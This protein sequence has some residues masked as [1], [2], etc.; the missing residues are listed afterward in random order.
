MIR[1]CYD[2]VACDGFKAQ[3]VDSI[4]MG[5]GLQ[6][7]FVG[8]GDGQL[9]LYDCRPNTQNGSYTL[10]LKDNIRKASKDRKPV[11][12]LILVE[13][14]RVL[15]GIMDNMVMA[16][17]SH[18]FQ[19]LSQL[20]DTKGCHLF[21][22]HERSSLLV[23]ANKKKLSIYMWQ[24]S[25]L[26]PRRE[27][28]CNEV[29]KLLQCVPGAIIVGCKRHYEIIDLANMTMSR[30]L[31]F[32]KEHRMVSLEVHTIAG[33]SS[34]TLLSV[35]AGLQGAMLDMSAFAKG[36]P[37]HYSGDSFSAGAAGTHAKS[38]L[39][40]QSKTQSF[41]DRIEWSTPPLSLHLLVPYIVTLQ[42]G[43]VEIHDPVSLNSL[44][45]ISFPRCESPCLCTAL[46]S[47][48]D[49]QAFFN[50]G[51]NQLFA[52]KM[53]P[54]SAQISD[55]MEAG[56]YEVAINLCAMTQASGQLRDVDVCQIHE[57][58]AMTLF[59]KG[60][61][62]GAMSNYISAKTTPLVL[63]RRFPDLVPVAL[64][65]SAGI[66]SSGANKLTG[67]VLQ[68]AAA[69]MATFCTHH[70]GAV[71]QAAELAEK[72]KS[73]G[74]GAAADISDP[75]EAIRLSELVDTVLLFSLIQCSPPQRTAAVDV[76]SSKNHCHIESSAVLLA[77]QGNAFTEALLWLYR[78]RNEHRR[79]LA[80]LTEDRCVGTGAWTKD[81]FY[82]WTAE[83]LRWLW[84]H[85]SDASLP[86]LALSA[87]RPVLEYDAN[88]GLSVL[89]M[90]PKGRATFGGKGVTVQ[91]VVTFL[92]SMQPSTLSARFA[93]NN[94]LMA[95]VSSSSAKTQGG[96]KRSSMR[97]QNVGGDVAIPLIN[98]RA[99]GVSYLEWLVGSGAAPPSMH[100][101]F[102]Q[103]LMEGIPLEKDID[104]RSN[105]LE[106]KDGDTESMLLYKIYR[107]KLQSFLQSSSEYHPD[108]ILKFLPQQFLHEYALLL[109]RL[110][111][112]EE[113][114][115]IY[116]EQLADLALAEAY[117]QRIY[118]GSQKSKLTGAANETEE[119]IYLVMIESMLSSANASFD[120]LPTV[121]SIAERN[122]EKL[123]PTAFLSLLPPT[124][125]LAML[126]SY[127]CI[128][129]EH[130]S[131][132]K[133]NLQVSAVPSIA[134]HCLKRIHDCP[135][136]KTI[137]NLRFAGPLHC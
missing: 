20:L 23:V 21:A 27:L 60:D 137:A 111:R 114:L 68:R 67:L 84:Y 18:S 92:E 81:Q 49:E 119:N 58:Y 87:L 31:D 48:G 47:P 30:L 42:E 122:F 105:D 135:T 117:C 79:V 127:L 131:T 134:A 121:I 33:R 75:D 77:S 38:A 43:G 101:E 44:Q 130:N 132:K 11:S 46:A 94:E 24:E 51:D 91:E 102:A 5:S 85:E 126:S 115:Q 96:S 70:R 25:G 93:N 124:V 76:L 8:T 125:P 63:L 80:A 107:R 118:E 74:I 34:S 29:P 50:T 37:G 86:Q 56:S 35:G 55:L 53:I 32:D 133:R 12:N 62:K 82:T 106:I 83:Y 97:H 61:F 19:I 15:I 72:T 103:L 109:S 65:A 17:D 73:A 4:A 7:L 3:K 16:Y 120:P 129:I 59:H 26:V 108:R 6:R 45:K 71:S 28:N 39:Y 128:V 52:L 98:G 89:T 36:F 113:V 123:D 116:I 66:V 9:L 88:L 110:H 40:S 95:N 1:N 64:H 100:D 10:A 99:L 57:K 13:S 2:K 54:L 78:S 104:H 69:A 90:R 14:W 22:V 41:G 136:L 112:H